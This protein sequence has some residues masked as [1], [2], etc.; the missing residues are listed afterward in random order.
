MGTVAVGIR[1]GGFQ[2]P[3]GDSSLP[4]PR[5]GKVR[6]SL[7]L[8]FSPLTG[9]PL[10][11]TTTAEVTVLRFGFKFQSPDGDSSL[12]DGRGYLAG[13]CKGDRFQSPDGDSSLP[14]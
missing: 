11:R 14:D 5:E 2:S 13:V 7:S 8:C 3:D 9:I 1:Q 10:C 4:D 6:R 12:P